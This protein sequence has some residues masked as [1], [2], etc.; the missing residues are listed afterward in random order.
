MSD[1]V[2]VIAFVL[3]VALIAQVGFAGFCAYRRQWGLL[4]RIG[5][6]FLAWLVSAPLVFLFG[7]GICAAGCPEEG[8][9]FTLAV[10]ICTPSL[11]IIYWLFKRI[12]RHP[13][14]AA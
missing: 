11:A 6:F 8:F 7:V 3:A 9:E 13:N 10:L 5:L 2:Y 1:I 4:G 12:G 14:G